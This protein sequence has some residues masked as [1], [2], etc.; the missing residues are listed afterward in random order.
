MNNRGEVSRAHSG[1]FREN[2]SN[3]TMRKVLVVEGGT[4]ALIRRF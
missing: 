1:D 2:P 4:L 3:V